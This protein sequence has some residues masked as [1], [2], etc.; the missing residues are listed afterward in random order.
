MFLRKNILPT[1]DILVKLTQ[2]LVKLTEKLPVGS[3]TTNEKS[4][5]P[6]IQ[7]WLILQ[8]F[9]RSKDELIINFL[10]KIHKSHSIQ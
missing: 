10:K 7:L 2:D 5:K 9:F 8:I 1:S 3:I 6:I 4:S